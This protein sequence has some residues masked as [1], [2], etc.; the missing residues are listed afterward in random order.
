MKK[1]ALLTSLFLALFAGIIYL[2][3]IKYKT[4]VTPVDVLFTDIDNE[5]GSVNKIYIG[6]SH[7]GTFHTYS[8]DSTDII[9]NFS[10]QGLDLFKQ[11]AILKKYIPLA[12]HLKK[13]YIGLDYEMLGQNQALSG[14][15]YLDRQFYKYI[16]TLYKNNI[17]N[18]LMA[19]SNFYRSNR[20]LAFLVQQN[21]ST[22][23]L[24]KNKKK[25]DLNFIP[26]TTGK[27]LNL[28]DCKKRALEHSV[29]KF[30]RSLSPENLAYLDAI[31]K[32]CAKNN[33][34]LIIFNPPKSDCF[35]DNVDP[36]NSLWAKTQIDSLLNTNNLKYY[37]FWRD[38][39]FQ[40]SD[41]E[42]YDHLNVLG[43]KKILGKL[44]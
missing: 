43:V 36:K 11:Y 21:N 13:V 28:K 29:I 20:D 39:S 15:E 24:K 3:E 30:K 31:I 7:T 16:D 10:F 34:E 44:N 40:D 38:T 27:K 25:E 42:D 23:G 17:T 5:I 4:Y 19:K 26:V 18:I 2:L 32:L 6:G 9:R 8:N 12:P 35:C 1:T 22:E 41:F 33:I 37:D 14:E